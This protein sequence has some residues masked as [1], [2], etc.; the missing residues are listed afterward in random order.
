MRK[1]A[2]FGVILAGVMLGLTGCSSIGEKAMSISAIYLV[3]AILAVLIL[4]GYLI[5]YK[6]KTRW[7]ILLLSAITV[8]NAGYWLLST[9]QTLEFALMANRISYF[10]S[11]FLPMSMLMIILTTIQ[12]NYPK[13]LPSL[14]T[15]ISLLVFLVAAS[16]GYSDIYYAEVSLVTLNGASVLEKVYGPWHRLYLFYLLGYF[17]TII[18]VSV[19]VI[20]TKK[21][22]NA[23]HAVIL[24]LAVFVN[25][26]LWLLEQLVK[27]DFE[28]LSVSY[29]LS[30]L[31]LISLDQLLCEQRSH[32]LSPTQPAVL[33]AEE[34]PIQ[35]PNDLLA[36]KAAHFAA[37]LATL[38]PTERKVYEQYLAG[39]STKEIMETLAIKENTLK[40]H[41]RN[42]YSKLGVSS[43][44]QMFELSAL[45]K[46]SSTDNAASEH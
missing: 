16:P 46:A 30:E 8:T 18:G 45:A 9:S 6:Q 27:V 28:L 34:E 29:I 11:V 42:I 32:E 31:F 36:D 15:G 44:K 39:K 7:F 24:S 14:L 41:N 22:N 20:C 3:T 12:I 10:G 21:I 17:M 25:I 13:W 19:S 26:G 1:S 23:V 38:T 37:Q 4:A 5:F 2:L 35:P 43:R 33:P 40:Y